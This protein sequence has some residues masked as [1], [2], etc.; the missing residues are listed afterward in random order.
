MPMS[1]QNLGAM[2]HHWHH[3]MS[4]PIYG[5]GSY[6]YAGKGNQLSHEEVETAR[7]AIRDLIDVAKDPKKRK[8]YGW[9]RKDYNELVAIDRELDR[10]LHTYKYGELPDYATFRVHLRMAEDSQGNPIVG[11]P[12]EVFQFEASGRTA[13][14]AEEAVAL[15]PSPRAIRIRRTAAGPVEFT[16]G[17]YRTLH[18]Y[19][20]ALA[21][22]RGQT[23]RRLGKRLA[24]AIGIRWV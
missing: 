18:S 20:L 1:Q 17:N 7:N 10:I 9:T 15:T 14:I 24:G 4:D 6:F 11:E 8:K 16:L 19:L 12:P 22:I 21:S 2:M 13:E 3:S 23:A 5:V